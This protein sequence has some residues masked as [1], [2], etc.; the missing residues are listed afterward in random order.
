MRTAL[1]IGG[2]P[3]ANQLHRL[4]SGVQVCVCV[5]SFGLGRRLVCNYSNDIYQLT[6]CASIVTFIS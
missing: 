1:V 5:A 6:L 3:I 2:L 4:K